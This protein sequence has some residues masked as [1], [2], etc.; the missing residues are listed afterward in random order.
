M[1]PRRQEGIQC[2]LCS[3]VHQWWL[4][5]YHRT[6]APSTSPWIVVWGEDQQK[7]Q[8]RLSQNSPRMVNVVWCWS[9][10]RSL[11]NIHVYSQRLTSGTEFGKVRWDLLMF[12]A[13]PTVVGWSVGKG[14][15]SGPFSTNGSTNDKMYPGSSFFG[16]GTLGRPA[17]LGRILPRRFISASVVTW[18]QPSLLI[19]AS[20]NSFPR[21]LV[22]PERF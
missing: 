7:S 12:R 9:L 14:Q 19:T 16:G 10:C 2:L 15:V 17:L 5:R 18:S 22:R 11:D 1:N 21:C 3:L 20:P 8:R 4:L 13:N 6:R